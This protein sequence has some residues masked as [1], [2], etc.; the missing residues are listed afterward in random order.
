[1]FYNTNLTLISGLITIR[2]LNN[3][4]HENIL[5]YGAS[6]WHWHMHRKSRDVVTL[7]LVLLFQKMKKLFNDDL[8]TYSLNYIK[9]RS[10]SNWLTVW[11]LFCGLITK[12][13]VND[14]NAETEN[15]G[16]WIWITFDIC[17]TL[18]HHKGIGMFKINRKSTWAL[19]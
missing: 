12:T 5:S 15:A 2:I 17:S 13:S 14:D 8:C 10:A 11:F 6:A 19:V 7:T 16:D 18:Q 3:A 4:S 9:S 1:M